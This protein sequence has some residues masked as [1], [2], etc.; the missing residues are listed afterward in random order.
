MSS[1]RPGITGE[2]SCGRLQILVLHLLYLNSVRGYAVG[3]QSWA[4]AMRLAF[5]FKGIILLGCQM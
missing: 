4:A 1:R 3:L 5:L 2:F